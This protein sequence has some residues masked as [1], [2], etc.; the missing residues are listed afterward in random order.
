MKI[1]DAYLLAAQAQKIPE[2]PD[3][4]MVKKNG[5]YYPEWA[6][7]YLLISAQIVSDADR[8]VVIPAG[9]ISQYVYGDTIAAGCEN[10]GYCLIYHNDGW[11]AV[12]SYAGWSIDKVGVGIQDSGKK[13]CIFT[14]PSLQKAKMAMLTGQMGENAWNSGITGHNLF[15]YGAKRNSS[16]AYYFEGLTGIYQ[17][18]EARDGNGGET[19]VATISTQSLGTYFASKGWRIKLTDISVSNNRYLWTTLAARALT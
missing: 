9:T 18:E 1:L 11:S 2:N 3:S 16:V 14:F 13:A 8:N 4:G 12:F 6:T 5:L 15:M 10:G 7:D 19:Y 17:L